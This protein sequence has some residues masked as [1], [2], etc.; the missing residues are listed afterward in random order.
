PRRVHA[1][2]AAADDA[3]HRRRGHPDVHPGDGRLR[4]AGPSW[5]RPDVDDRQGRPGPVHDRTRLAVRL[6]A[7]GHAHGHDACGYVPRA[8]RIAQG[9]VRVTQKR[10]PL[11][12]AFA[13]LIYAFLFAPIVV[14]II[15]SFNISRRNF[16]WLGFTT[17][18][19]PKL[20]A[21]GDLIDALWI[22]I[23]VAAIAV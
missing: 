8:P 10:N 14:L 2:R 1:C 13:I 7:R 21:N 17:D 4:D 15:F 22:T 5:W 23:Q 20:F 19:Y 11:L 3:G 16:V 6:G 9:D 12:T 18:W